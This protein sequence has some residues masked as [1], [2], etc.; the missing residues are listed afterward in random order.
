MTVEYIAREPAPAQPRNKESRCNLADEIVQKRKK[1][2]L[3]DWI[4]QIFERD[5]WFVVGVNIDMYSYL[6][7]WS[8]SPF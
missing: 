7:W 6:E 1:K 5:D 8:H 2:E 4:N 3:R